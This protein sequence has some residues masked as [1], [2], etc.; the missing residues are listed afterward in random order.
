MATNETLI[1][2][3][4]VTFAGV[5]PSEN[6][7]TWWSIGGDDI[8]T[9]R[10]CF[11]DDEYVFNEDG[12]FQNVLG[13]ETWLETWQ[14]VSGDGCGAP[15]APHD[16]SSPGTWSLD[17]YNNTITIVGSG[18]Y[19]GIPK[20]TN[21]GELTS[22]DDT[23][24]NITYNILS[25]GS[26]EMTINI[27][28]G[29]GVWWQFTLTKQGSTGSNEPV[30]NPTYNVTLKLDAN[31]LP[32]G[33]DVNSVYVIGSFNGW[34]N[35]SNIMV[36][37]NGTLE[38]TLQL[39]NGT[40]EFKYYVS[41]L[42]TAETLSVG[43]TCTLTTYGENGTEY[44]NRVV[45]VTTDL[46]FDVVGWGSCSG[47]SEQSY[48]GPYQFYGNGGQ[49]EG[50][51][52]PLYTEDPNDGTHH[53][54]SFTDRNGASLDLYMPNDTMNHAVT[55]PSALYPTH[56][57]SNDV[58]LQ[59]GTAKTYDING[60]ES[61]SETMVWNSVSRTIDGDDQW[62]YNNEIQKYRAGNV[63]ID[64]T[65]G[66]MVITLRKHD[67]GNYYSSRVVMDEEIEALK[68]VPGY[69][70]SVSF[71][72]RLPSN[73]SQNGGNIPVWPAFWT[74]G[75]NH[76]KPVGQGRVNWPQCGEV[77]VMEWTPTNRPITNYGVAIHST[78]GQPEQSYNYDNA[79]FD[80]T[81]ENTYKVDMIYETSSD[82]SLVFS[83]NNNEVA[84]FDNVSSDY[85]ENNNDSSQPKYMGLLMN[86][87]F[88]GS[89]TAVTSY[90]QPID[91]VS[92]YVKDVL[93]ERRLNQSIIEK[94]SEVQSL[95]S[96]SIEA[97]GLTVSTTE[98]TVNESKTVVVSE[99]DSNGNV[100]NSTKNI[101]VGVSIRITTNETASDG[102]EMTATKLQNENPEVYNE[103]IGQLRAKYAEIYNVDISRVNVV[104]RDG[105][106]IADV[107][108]LTEDSAIAIGDPHI[109]PIYGDVYELP[110]KLT[111]YRM[112][113]GT[114]LVVNAGTRYFTDSEKMAIREY[115]ISQTGNANN[116]E[117][118]I[119]DGVVQ[120][121]VFI[122]CDDTIMTYN[123]DTRTVES[124]KKVNYSINKRSDGMGIVFKLHSA[125][126]G[127][128]KV[129]C[130]HYTNPQLFS[131]VIANVERNANECVG[132]LVR[133]YDTVA[134]ELDTLNS[135]ES[136][137]E[138]ASDALVF[139]N[140]K[141]NPIFK[142]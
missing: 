69:T 75:T 123:F 88:G 23:P 99:T 105:S 126:H 87:A 139:T 63:A 96:T 120:N 8:S 36:N 121:R 81:Q 95:I 77:D 38:T 80:V 116:V 19:L 82:R 7:T 3:W 115:Y 1:G 124:N 28:S 22:A 40:Y 37:T 76:W 56:H 35:N 78:A 136:K 98:I 31:S 135:T 94:N 2:T 112:V 111:N 32:S 53:T 21:D 113:E 92:M 127:T 117:N 44:T 50:W 9:Y 13:S 20:A 132:L 73:F 101:D 47:D 34:S 118:L 70:N 107:Y 57:L 29:S 48:T 5:G 119:T 4:R 39:E 141:V 125:S 11:A 90:D 109:K 93:V 108:V 25:F 55:S 52:Y 85:F 133:N 74:L 46:V 17:T 84:R 114:N 14:G 138:V 62:W 24:S 60:V 59:F 79:S 104:L 129:E 134:F 67:D 10:P 72:G 142:M 102:S 100:V 103:L 83:V 128:V 45:T 18:N 54:H 131:G 66:E 61:I 41:N 26:N 122:T 12:T 58:E 51:Y 86:M 33:S 91:D 140:N 49:G 15:V 97:N 43:S 68:M 89:Y 110:N 130:R 64:S 30:D 42:D 106:I 6:D 65:S 27:E 137:M 71:T 16:G